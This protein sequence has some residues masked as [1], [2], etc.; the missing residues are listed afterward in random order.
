MIHKMSYPQLFVDPP[1]VLKTICYRLFA[2]DGSAE[3][4]KKH[5]GSSGL[6]AFGESS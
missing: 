6:G 5:Q 2:T 4:L 1:V 3:N